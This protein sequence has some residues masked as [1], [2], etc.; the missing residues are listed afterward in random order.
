MVLLH[1]F[2][3]YPGLIEFVLKVALVRIVE[4]ERFHLLLTIE[5]SLILDKVVSSQLCNAGEETIKP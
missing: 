1:A 3:H 4:G 2:I 5:R